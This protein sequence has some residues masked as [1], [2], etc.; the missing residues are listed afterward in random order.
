MGE[1]RSLE[2][3]QLLARLQAEIVEE[4]APRLLIGVQRVGLP[5][6]SIQRQHQLRPQPL[7][8]RL[9]RH[10]RTEL[11]DEIGV[12]PERKI[13]V[14]PLL[15]CR[16]AE[17]FE[18]LDLAAGE[19][20]VGEIRQ[21]WAAPQS[22]R[23]AQL[24]G[25][26]ARLGVAG[27]LKQLLEP[28]RVELAGSDLQ[29]V[30]A[31]TRQQHVVAERLAQLRDVTLQ[32]LGGGLRPPL[33]PQAI[34]QSLACDE[35]VRVQQQNREQLALP[36]RADDERPIVIGDLQGSEDAEVHFALRRRYHAIQRLSVTRLLPAVTGLGGAARTVLRHTSKGPTQARKES[37]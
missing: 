25:S 9:A 3:L 13:G 37:R 33:A 6:R 17:L 22:Q 28:L 21:R 14:D 12:A 8:Q 20:V 24:L 30:A 32:R 4:D 1:D 35:L 29:H 27:L 11:A 10:E 18:A 15:E 2:L 5:A 19:V 34:D 36:S 23:Q 26:L 16:Q 31:R 7:E